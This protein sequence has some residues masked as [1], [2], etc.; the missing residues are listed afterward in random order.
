MGILSVLKIPAQRNT[1][2]NNQIKLTNFDE[3]KCFT[4]FV[5]YIALVKQLSVQTCITI[6]KVTHMR[7]YSHKTNKLIVTYIRNK[8]GNEEYLKMK[9][10]KQTRK[11]TS[12]LS[13][14]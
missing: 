3:R 10:N 8:M 11:Q 1:Q 6:V 9:T 13:Y 7:T 2:R 5:I 12:R 4:K 14:N